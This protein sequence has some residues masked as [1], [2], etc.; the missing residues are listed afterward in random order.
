MLQ[1]RRSHSP[2][3][4]LSKEGVGRGGAAPAQPEPHGNTNNGC[5]MET[6]QQNTH[7]QFVE[8]Q[9][10]VTGTGREHRSQRQTRVLN[11]QGRRNTTSR[12]GASAQD[13]CGT[14]GT[15]PEEATRVL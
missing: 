2:P 7:I 8:M 4:T 12:S 3:N 10:G 1:A 13:G 15:R 9:L 11:S 6:N 14:A 5:K